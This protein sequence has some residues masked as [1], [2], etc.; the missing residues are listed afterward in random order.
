M[1]P[2]KNSYRFNFDKIKKT[3]FGIKY[4]QDLILP[5]S[6]NKDFVL[7]EMFSCGFLLA[8]KK[9]A[10][11]AAATNF[12]LLTDQP[13]HQRSAFLFPSNSQFD[14]TFSGRLTL[15]ELAWP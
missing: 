3:N 4:P 14:A 8:P 1:K 2:E 15:S 9:A 13:N 6:M 10:A 11:E 12:G 7:W 5:T